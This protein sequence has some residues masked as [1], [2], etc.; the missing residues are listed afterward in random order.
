M[1]DLPSADEIR[2]R[3]HMAWQGAAPIYADYVAPF[4]A[5][6]GQLGLHQELGPLNSGEELLDVGSGTGDIAIQLA[7]LGTNVTGIDFAAEMVSIAND[8]YP[9]INFVEADVEQ[10]PFA[11][12]SFDRAVA[13]YTAHHFARPDVAFAEIRRVLKPGSILSIIHPIQTEQPSWGSFQLSLNEA[14][15]AEPM[16]GGPLINCDDPKEYLS[17]LSEAGFSNVKAEKRTKPIKLENLDII[18]K[19]GWAVGMMD[20]QSESV[21]EQ[22][23]AGISKRAEPYRTENG[24]YDFPDRVIIASGSA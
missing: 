3:E 7:D 18:I 16:M 1:A 20:Q 23:L 9:K 21:Q 19:A 14:V 17:F 8:R 12:D 11:N 10:L 13:N 15:P 22:V 2:D 4:T 6:S 24:Y 5:Y